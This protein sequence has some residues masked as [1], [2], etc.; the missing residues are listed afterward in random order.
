MTRHAP[1][2]L[3]AI[4][5]ANGLNDCSVGAC[6]SLAPIRCGDVQAPAELKG[7]VVGTGTADGA[8]VGFAHSVLKDAGLTDGTDYSFLTVGDG[9]P[10]M[11]AF[12]SGE[13]DAYSAPTAYEAILDQR[14]VAVR[15]ITPG[16]YARFFGNGFVP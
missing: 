2:G 3:L 12:S 15:D 14:G 16:E 4:L 1:F 6:G 7:K 13:I 5:L 11:A 9:G 10:T 8:E